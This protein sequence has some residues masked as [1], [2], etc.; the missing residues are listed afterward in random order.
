LRRTVAPGEVWDVGEVSF[1]RGGTLALTL[2]TDAADLVAKQSA[3][4]GRRATTC[5]S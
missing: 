3:G 2:T 4:R 5:C 1:T